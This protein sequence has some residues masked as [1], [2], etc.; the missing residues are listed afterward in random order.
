M[1]G[2]EVEVTTEKDACGRGC[3]GTET[4]VYSFPLS[5]LWAGREA[6]VV[7]WFWGRTGSLVEAAY[8]SALL[9]LRAGWAVRRW[10]LRR[11]GAVGVVV[12]AA[13]DAGDYAVVRGVFTI[14][15][16]PEFPNEPEPMALTYQDYM[17]ME[18]CECHESEWCEHGRDI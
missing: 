2:D 5:H 7:G 9:P 13:Y 3:C 1:C 10:W 17:D 15:S 18:Y 16:P 8:Q 11:K 6:A 12:K 4:E 14:P